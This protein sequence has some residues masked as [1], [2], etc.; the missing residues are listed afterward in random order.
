MKR[1]LSAL[2]ARLAKKAGSS[3]PWKSW[4]ANP[5]EDTCREILIRS[6][7]ADHWIGKFYN[8]EWRIQ[9]P[10]EKPNQP[11]ESGMVRFLDW[12]YVPR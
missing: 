6:C 4:Q 10:G 2:K 1:D 11:V 5:P 8:G 7:G 9:H 3:S 12:M